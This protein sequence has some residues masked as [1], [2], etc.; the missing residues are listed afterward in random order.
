MGSS[1]N[2]AITVTGSSM[3]SAWAW[4]NATATSSSRV[5]CTLIS[6]PL[7]RRCAH[8][9]AASDSQ[10]VGAVRIGLQVREPVIQTGHT[11]DDLVAT[12]ALVRTAGLSS[13]WA[14]HAY[15]FDALSALVAVAR[16]VPDIELGTAVVPT[17]PRHPL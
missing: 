15:E 9:I 8:P 12:A 4:A 16:E 6:D 14:A 13:F 11:V 7:V 1:S 3:V 2:V 5:A 17:Y 10:Y